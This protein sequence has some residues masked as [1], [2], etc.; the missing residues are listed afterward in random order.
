MKIRERN[1]ATYVD[2]LRATLGASKGHSKSGYR[3]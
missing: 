2:P 3:S 1:T